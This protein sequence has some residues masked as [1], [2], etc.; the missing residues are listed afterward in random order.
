MHSEIMDVPDGRLA[1]E[2]ELLGRCRRCARR[3]AGQCAVRKV[4]RLSCV[5][6]ASARY[7]VPT[8]LIGERVAVAE[9][10]GR[11]VIADSATGE[12]VAEHLARLTCNAI[13]ACRTSSSGRPGPHPVPC[14]PG[15]PA[16]RA[17]SPGCSPAAPARLLSR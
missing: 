2:W 14:G 3:R 15:T 1:R 13:R 10:G 7:S 9:A 11:L 12:V 5:R 6:F 4:D 17:A 16:A 8:R